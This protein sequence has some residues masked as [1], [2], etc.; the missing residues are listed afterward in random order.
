MKFKMNL[1]DLLAVFI[2][3]FLGGFAR[4]M[5]DQLLHDSVSLL[6]TTT[7][8]IAGSFLLAFITYGLVI[9]FDVPNWLIVGLGTGFIGAFTTFSTLVLNLVQNVPGRPDYAMTIFALN[10]I[11]GL[12]AALAGYLVA[13]SLGWGRKR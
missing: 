11:L 12:L 3:G 2:G 9:F 10:L 5:V 4:F 1:V 6:G 13:T 8:N 7:V